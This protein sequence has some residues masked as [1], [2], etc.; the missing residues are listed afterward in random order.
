M[1]KAFRQSV[2]RG[3]WNPKVSFCKN[4]FK[5]KRP[6]LTAPWC[7]MHS[8]ALVYI[9]KNQNHLN[10]VM[11][12]K[13]IWELSLTLWLMHS[14]LFQTHAQRSQ[15]WM[16][17]NRLLSEANEMPLT[18]LTCRHQRSATAWSRYMRNNQMLLFRNGPLGQRKLKEKNTSAL[19]PCTDYFRSMFMMEI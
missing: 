12:Q 14:A 7:W 6:I 15:N 16:K 4:E 10:K 9:N 17:A 5:F 19:T 11:I 2:H 13:E 18:R 8:I 3:L 1:K